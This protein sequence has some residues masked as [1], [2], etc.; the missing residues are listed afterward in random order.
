MLN[1]LIKR[2]VK[3][4]DDYGNPAT[5]SAYGRL[6]AVYGI[7][8]N[9]VLFA[10][11]LFAGFISGSVAI[12]AE[13]FNN[14]SDAG[15]SVISLLGFALAS[16][17]PDP[18]HPFGYG[19]IEYFSGLVIAALII[20]MGVEL[21]HAS[22]SKIINP[23]EIVP[24]ILPA[25]ILLVSIAVKVYMSI[26]N[27][28]I[29]KKIGS[30]A[31]EATATDSLTDSISTVV[32]L[33]SM[34]LAWVFKINIDGYA[35]LAVA[36]FICYAGFRS[37]AEAISPLLGRAPEPELIDDISSI[38]SEFPE[39][40]GIHDLIVHDYG[41]GRLFVSLH[42]EVD[43]HG[44]FFKAHDVIDQVEYVL[45]DRLNCLATIHLD[46]IECDD[47]TVSTMRKTISDEIK[48]S[49]S[50]DI[51]I[52]DF[53]MVPGETHTNLI[54]DAVLPAGCRMTDT[55]AMAAI[56]ELVSE[57]HENHFAV[58]TIDRSYV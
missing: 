49:I 47:D 12:T 23:E 21:G 28:R 18:D 9:L 37:M 27:R 19:R 36:A 41:P 17:R 8:L 58:V 50:P 31:M 4:P 48:A 54:F 7:F 57:K 6:C 25:A 53:R 20:I 39:I 51:S 15:S 45:K 22:I 14:L 35:G 1:L 13:A 56:R 34:I 32:V 26:Y 55:E 3:N 52:H 46:P 33:L 43:G 2:F 16:K 10:C 44:D 24:G 42:A 40:V 38:V 30:V 29:G 5:R 11:K